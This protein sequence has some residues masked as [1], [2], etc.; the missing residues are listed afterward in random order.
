M[1]PGL[2]IL[3]SSAG[4]PTWQER[5]PHQKGDHMLPPEQKKRYEAFFA[6]TADNGILDSKTTVMIQLGASMIAGCYP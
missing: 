6:S 2:S 5:I 1:T 3:L 4:G